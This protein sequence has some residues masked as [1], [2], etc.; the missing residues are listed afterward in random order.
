MSEKLLKLSLQI[1]LYTIALGMITSI[2]VL[3]LALDA[4]LIPYRSVSF[5]HYFTLFYGAPI[6]FLTGIF[7]LFFKTPGKICGALSI[8]IA[9]LWI[10][11]I[12]WSLGNK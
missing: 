3:V 10:V 5:L 1:L 8:L 6:L 9:L 12:Y 4:D 2:V 11:D 7:L